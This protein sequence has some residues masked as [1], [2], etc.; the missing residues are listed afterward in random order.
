MR[1]AGTCPLVKR[2]Q[3]VMRLKSDR[4]GGGLALQFIVDVLHKSPQIFTQA[5][6]KVLEFTIVYLLHILLHQVSKG[7]GNILR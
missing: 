6:G 4:V 5:V 7:D 3:A 1:S 2:L